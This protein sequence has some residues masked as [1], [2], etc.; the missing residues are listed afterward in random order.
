M[1][2]A[3]TAGLTIQESEY[4][5]I[6]CKDGKSVGAAYPQSLDGT[7][8]P[9]LANA[10]AWSAAAE[11]LNVLLAE[12]SMRSIRELAPASHP[13]EQEKYAEA[14]RKIDEMKKAAIAKAT[15][16]ALS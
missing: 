3:P 13:W 10:R 11:M 8:F 9:D 6:I 15:G 5:V 16:R 14:E 1:D 2:D 7:D 12:E 4:G